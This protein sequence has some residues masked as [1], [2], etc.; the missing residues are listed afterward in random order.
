MN[1]WGMRFY[2][3]PET[4]EFEITVDD[5]SRFRV[6]SGS[7]GLDGPTTVVKIVDE[8]RMI[9][10]PIRSFSDLMQGRKQHA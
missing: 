2:R 3:G 5:T 1:D 6:G 8:T 4:E 7:W 9:V 10:R